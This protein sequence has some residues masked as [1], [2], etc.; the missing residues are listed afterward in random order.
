MLW[1]TVERRYGDNT[2]ACGR[3]LGRA[4]SVRARHKCGHHP[5]EHLGMSSPGVAGSMRH[6]KCG[7]KPK[8]AVGASPATHS[9]SRLP[10]CAIDASRG[11]ESQ[12]ESTWARRDSRVKRNTRQPTATG[13]VAGNFLVSP[14]PSCVARRRPGAVRRPAAAPARA[15]SRR[16]LPSPLLGWCWCTLPS[17]VGNGRG[18][19]HADGMRQQ[20]PGCTCT[21]RR[22]VT[23]GKQNTPSVSF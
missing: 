9:S 15:L 10:P 20:R 23:Y 8:A 12:E 14:V 18:K 4:G 3:G 11:R 21:P 19:P 1:S 5:L 7:P 17:A 6:N 2:C 22:H 16:R 13:R